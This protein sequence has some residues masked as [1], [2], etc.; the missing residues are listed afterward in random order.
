MLLVLELPQLTGRRLLLEAHLGVVIIDGEEGLLGKQIGVCAVAPAP[1]LR[2]HHVL[3]QD[4]PGLRGHHLQ[5]LQHK[6]QL[7]VRDKVGQR[8]A[9]EARPEVFVHGVRRS[10]R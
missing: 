7:T 8:Y 4:L 5:R 3:R 2:V 10:E 1:R 9:A 6:G